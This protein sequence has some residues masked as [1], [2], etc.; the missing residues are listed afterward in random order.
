M[1]ET[2]FMLPPF[3]V[4]GKPNTECSK[5]DMVVHNRSGLNHNSRREH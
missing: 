2:D 5:R 1:I 3:V 4:D